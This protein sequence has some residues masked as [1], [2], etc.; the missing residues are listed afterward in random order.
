MHS[1]FEYMY[2]TV[3]RDSVEI[4]DIGNCA[5]ECFNDQGEA[6]YL[7][8]NTK[9]GQT[10]IIEFGPYDATSSEQIVR[11]KFNFKYKRIDYDDYKVKNAIDTFITDKYKKV[12][13]VIETSQQY[14]FDKLQDVKSCIKH[15]MSNEGPL[16]WS[17]LQNDN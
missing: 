10:E 8:V 17:C 16:D 11:T 6:Y 9:I 12:T 15:D 13:Q 7:I 4:E 5:L 1:T 14:V 3:S 2:E